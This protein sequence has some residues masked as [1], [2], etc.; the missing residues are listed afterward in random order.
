MDLTRLLEQLLVVLTILL[1][2]ALTVLFGHYLLM[3][4]RAAR[5]RAKRKRAMDAL[6]QIISRRQVSREALAPLQRIP[7]ILRMRTL[8]ELAPSLTGD[9]HHQLQKAAA[10]TGVTARARRL[11]RSPFWW[12]RLLGTQ[13]LASLDQG[14]ECLPSLLADRNLAVRERAVEWASEHPSRPV[15]EQLLLLISRPAEPT[16]FF[17]KDS[18]AR[19]GDE[20]IE[21]LAEYL[22]RTSGEA[23][24]PALELAL[25]M[26]DPDLTAPTLTLARDPDPR[27]RAASLRLLGSIGGE[28]SLRQI[29]D[30][31]EDPAPIVRA[32]AAAALGRLR[33]WPASTRLADM[34][35]DP[36]WIVRRAAGL[37]LRDV[38]SPGIVLLRRSA[39]S[40]DPLAGQL[41][42]QVL[43]LPVDSDRS[44]DDS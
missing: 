14:E 39:A 34:L 17:A 32:E 9:A 40:D 7:M 18:L 8:L 19:M 11:I 20:V 44:G 37:A 35:D 4:L 33:H 26:S 41:A 16:L 30:G 24:V 29:R 3:A 28:E 12:R 36:E 38:G 23:A 1:V 13:L 43:E 2:L 15:I 5:W 22:A 27:V 42:R 6:R 21:P 25:E 31:L 10:M